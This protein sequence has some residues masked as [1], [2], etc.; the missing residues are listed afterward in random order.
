MK[1][2]FAFLILLIFLASCSLKTQYVPRTVRI[3]CPSMRV[4]H[5][6]PVLEKIDWEEEDLI[7][8]IVKT[9]YPELRVEYVKCQQAE[10]LWNQLYDQCPSVEVIDPVEGSITFDESWNPKE[11]E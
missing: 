11:K 3:A 4:Q 1:K 2:S 9:Y 5:K 8:N 6:C 7:K 10:A